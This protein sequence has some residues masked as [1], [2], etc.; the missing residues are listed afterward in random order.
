MSAASSR[1]SAVLA[2]RFATEVGL[3]AAAAWAAAAHTRNVLAAITLGI[4]AAVVVAA[5]WGVWIA[6]ASRRRLPD[7]ARLMLELALFATAVA[8]LALARHVLPAVVL[9]VVGAATAVGVR[10]LRDEADG[11]AGTPAGDREAVTPKSL[12]EAPELA[13]ALEPERAEAPPAAPAPQRRPRG[14]DRARPS[15]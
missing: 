14:R 11:Q 7:P 12:A 13:D 5:V 2:V 9:G 15:E 10:L 1:T 4:A 6:P 3:V 8:G